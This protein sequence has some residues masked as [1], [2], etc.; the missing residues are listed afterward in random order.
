M[1]RGGGRHCREVGL[2]RQG[3]D[4]DADGGGCQREEGGRHRQ[5]EEDGAVRSERA[6]AVAPMR[7]HRF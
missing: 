1:R 7:A 4:G 5:R 3:V 6:A 2:C